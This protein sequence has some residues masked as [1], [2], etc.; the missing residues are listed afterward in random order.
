M[1]LAFTFYSNTDSSVMERQLKSELEPIGLDYRVI[2][3]S[4][5]LMEHGVPVFNQLLSMTC[6]HNRKPPTEIA[7][8]LIRYLKRKKYSAAYMVKARL[9][10]PAERRAPALR[11]GEPRGAGTPPSGVL[12]DFSDLYYGTWTI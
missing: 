4:K 10:R 6:Q 1:V 5:L 9:T 11:E 2:V 7:P 12:T 3:S 8:K